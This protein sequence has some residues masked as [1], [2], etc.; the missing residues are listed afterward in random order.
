MDT[1]DEL[2][3]KNLPG[4]KVVLNGLTLDDITLWQTQARRHRPSDPGR[5]SVPCQED[6]FAI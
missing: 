2:A 1:P 6:K 4:T 5:Y 3:D